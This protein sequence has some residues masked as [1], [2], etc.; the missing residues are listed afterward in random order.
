M[1]LTAKAQESQ[2]ICLNQQNF[3]YVIFDKNI[4]DMIYDADVVQ[5]ER[6]A[7]RKDMVGLRL[8]PSANDTPIGCMVELEGNTLQHLWLKLSPT[9]QP[10]VRIYTSAVQTTEFVPKIAAQDTTQAQFLQSAKKMSKSQR[11]SLFVA[12]SIA[13]AKRN[14]EVTSSMRTKAQT[15]LLK[16]ASILQLGADKGNISL[17]PISIGVDA[18]HLYFCVEIS[19]TSNVDYYIDIQGFQTNFKRKGLRAGATGKD[20]IQAVGS[21]DE[22][23]VL[24]SKRRCRY[25]LVYELFTLKKNQSLEFFIRE[26]NGGRNID[27]ELPAKYLYEHTYDL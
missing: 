24:R 26:T 9:I 19:N 25:V 2:T 17:L 20:F 7:V 10:T 1:T 18:T 21:Y 22:P 12:D 3:V 27:V 11:D 4:I 5:D 23:L 8:L 15:L 14:A 13:T 16:K 6:P